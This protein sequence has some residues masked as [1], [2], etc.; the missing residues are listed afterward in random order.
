MQLF[1]NDAPNSFNLQKYYNS[2]GIIIAIQVHDRP[3]FYSIL[4]DSLRVAHDIDKI[5][6]DAVF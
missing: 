1:A 4:I 2:N 3:Q 6:L 5:D